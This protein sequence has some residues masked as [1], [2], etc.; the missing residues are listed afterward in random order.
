[1]KIVMFCLIICV[2]AFASENQEK[3]A[4]K[5]I[6]L[7][8]EVELLNDEY[9]SEREKIL[10]E[11]KAL[12]VQKAELES[13]LRSEDVRS[14]QLAKRR[15]ELKNEIEKDAVRS[16][17][18]EPLVAKTLGELRQYVESS[19]PFQKEQRLESLDQLQQKIDKK[20]ITATRAASQLWSLIEDER[21]LARETT[22][23]KQTI[24]IQGQRSLAQ[25]AKLGMLFLYFQT[26]DGQV[27]MA[28]RRNNEW[29]FEAFS[30]QNQKTQ[31][32]AFLESLKKQI[33]QG[34]F[35]LPVEI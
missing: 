35:S 13:N 14:Q 34:Y 18:L 25:V 20:E 17:T 15:L 8:Q 26:D 3:L 11:L 22:L 12:S 16:K 7:R 29:V 21:R 27:G 5:V 4:Q 2:Q 23:N 32:I 10:N 19:L 31:T 1:M 24:E 9:K 6:E 30:D 28:K 33:R